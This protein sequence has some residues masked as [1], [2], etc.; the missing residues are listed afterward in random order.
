ME[1]DLVDRLQRQ[2]THDDDS[3][4]FDAAAKIESLE[5]ENARLAAIVER[6]PK[7]VV[8]GKYCV[9]LE[10]GG[11]E[12]EFVDNQWACSETCYNI[13][14]RRRIEAAA[15]AEGGE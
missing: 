2:G 6:L 10:D 7:C 14:C 15:S 13:E 4:S 9:T 11:P 3:L 12:A 5:A 8:C 1:R